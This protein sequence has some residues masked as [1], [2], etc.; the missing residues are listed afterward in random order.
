MRHFG[1]LEWSALVF[2][3]LV[4][5]WGAR[6]IWTNPPPRP[7]RPPRRLP[8]PF[9]VLGVLAGVTESLGVMVGAT[10][11]AILTIAGVVLG[12]ILVIAGM[13]LGLYLF[14]VLIKAL[15]AMA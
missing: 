7:P 8:G 5:Y 9:M 13:I 10:L 6:Q 4:L 14:L 1:L 12:L 2:G 15:W 3:G 11:G